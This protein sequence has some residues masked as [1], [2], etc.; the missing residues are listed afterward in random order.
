M[1]IEVQIKQLRETLNSLIRRFVILERG[2]AACC[3][4]T[5]SQCC[6]LA[7]IGQARALSVVDLAELLGLDKSTVSR[8]VE[9]LVNQS[10]I[11]RETDA[12]DRRFVTLQLTARGTDLYSEIEQRMNRYFQELVENI[13]AEKRTQVIESMDYLAK[14]LQKT[15]CC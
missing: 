6:A 11:V 12:R 1:E 8:L 2:D 5:I 10:M 9:S 3:N 15:K 7:E 14:A 4:I 13:P